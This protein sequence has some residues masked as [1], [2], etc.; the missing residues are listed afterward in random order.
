MCIL[1]NLLQFLNIINMVIDISSIEF[2]QY[3]LW[4]Q[5][6]NLLYKQ[7]YQ[8]ALQNHHQ[9]IMCNKQHIF[10]HKVK[11]LEPFFYSFILEYQ[12][13][14]SESMKLYCDQLVMFISLIRWMKLK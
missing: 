4:S 3:L 11:C 14:L 13:V 5:Q 8:I 1:C 7:L 2:H 6:G 10:V 12:I 9:Y